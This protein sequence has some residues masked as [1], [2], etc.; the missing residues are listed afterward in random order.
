MARG[1]N[2]EVIG[3]RARGSSQRTKGGHGGVEETTERK[4]VLGFV[5]LDS[6]I[7]YLLPTAAFNSLPIE[8]Q[9]GH[10]R[11]DA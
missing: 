10:L 2:K 11:G 4:V 6:L 3:N 7:G 5:S 1:K 9:Q 8:T